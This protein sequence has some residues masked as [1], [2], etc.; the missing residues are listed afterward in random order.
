MAKGHLVG[1]DFGTGGAK[2]CVMNTDG[3][4][5]AYAFEEFEL[6]HDHPGWSE[7]DAAV[8]WP[9]AC[10][11][12]RKCLTDSGVSGNDIGGVA[13][14]SALPSMV[15]VD[16]DGNPV[17]RAYNLLDK[18]AHDQVERLKK[19]IGDDRIFD[20]SGYRLED[21]PSIV[22]LLWEMTHRP[23]QFAN[24]R[25]ALTIDG[26]VTLKL[27]GKAS[28]HYSGA[29]FYGVAYNMRRRSFDDELLAELRLDPDLFPPIY[30]CDDLVGEVSRDAAEATGIAAGTPVAAGQVD[31]NASWLGAGAIEVGDFQSNLGTVGNFGVIHK[32]SEYNF[33]DIGRLMINFPYTV[34]SESTYVTVPTTLTGGQCL[35]YLRDAFSQYEV[36]KEEAGGPSAYDQ[37]T[38]QAAAVPAGSDGLVALPFLMG[39]RTPIWDTNARGL[40]FGLSL[41]HTK[42]H[43]VR[44]MMEG[45]AFA[46][47]D[48]FRLVR[49]AGLRINSP[50]VLNEGGAVSRVWRQ[51]IADVFNVPVVLVKRRTGA[52]YGD[53]ILAG[54]AS[55]VLPGYRVA[56][57]WTEY[58][59]PIEPN[60]AANA[61]YEEYFALYK[62]IYNNVK[63]DYQR[64]AELREK[65]I[66]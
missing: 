55:G 39:E 63:T 36:E 16:A 21:H 29:A 25:K 27:T 3:E 41:N 45:V 30:N 7:H 46:M 24:V 52:P 56:R 13:V 2:A 62:S 42:G 54:V 23:D 6:V 1:I 19:E 49:E 43:L 8:Y 51:I 33:S 59:D 14:S 31:C 60:P 4:V 15:M 66:R 34:D 37:L 32:S 38:E 64:L 53:A 48:S 12:I 50:M 5:L 26:Y 11:L 57:E 18:R 44:A 65:S 9:A 20:I 22:N 35:R 28:A 47:Y 17:N 61:I 58:V 10:R 40:L